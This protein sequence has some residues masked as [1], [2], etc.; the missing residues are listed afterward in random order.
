MWAYRLEGIGEAINGTLFSLL[1]L[2]SDLV[3][4]LGGGGK[5]VMLGEKPGKTNS[6]EEYWE[7]ILGESS[8]PDY[9][10]LSFTDRCPL[11]LTALMNEVQCASACRIYARIV[12][13]NRL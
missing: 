7:F 6:T 10:N 5:H 9:V 11:N 2:K 13:L 12:S 8:N 3:S 1:A 4:L